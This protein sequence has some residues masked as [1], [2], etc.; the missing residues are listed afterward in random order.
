V[1]N[2][3]FNKLTSIFVYEALKTPKLDV[4]FV[5]S[6]VVLI[7]WNHLI[8]ALSYQVTLYREQINRSAE[9]ASYI[10]QYP[11]SQPSISFRNLDHQQKYSVHVQA[12]SLDKVYSHSVKATFEPSTFRICIL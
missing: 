4:L 12:I 10:M 8:S 2:V 9:V 7:T 3:C 5:H 11:D 1:L 6:N